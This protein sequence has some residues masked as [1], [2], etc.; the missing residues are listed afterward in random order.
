[1]VANIANTLHAVVYKPA[2]QLISE[3]S[4]SDNWKI[5]RVTYVMLSHIADG[6]K[7][8]IETDL[9]TVTNVMLGGLNDGDVPCAE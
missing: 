5:R 1:M 6:C 4:R 3:C 7:N 2:T 8:Q 9:K